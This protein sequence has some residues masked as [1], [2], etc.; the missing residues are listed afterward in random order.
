MKI[1]YVITSY[2]VGG[3]SIQLHRMCKYLSKRNNEI[4]LVSMT[5]PESSEMVDEY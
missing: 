5:K 2:G 4:V 3:A 1:L